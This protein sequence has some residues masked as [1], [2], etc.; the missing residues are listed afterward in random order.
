[1]NVVVIILLLALWAVVLLPGLVRARRAGSPASSVSRFHRDL[2]RLERTGKAAGE[3]ASVG[4]APSPSAR[5]APSTAGRVSWLRAARRDPDAGERHANPA[6]RVRAMAAFR[7]RRRGAST[8]HHRR[9]LGALTV[10][11]RRRVT[12][13]GLLTALALTLVSGLWLGGPAWG[14]TA[15]VGLALVAYCALLRRVTARERSRRVV[16]SR[17]GE[18]GDARGGAG[19]PSGEHSSSEPVLPGPDP[20]PHLNGTAAR[21][22]HDPRDAKATPRGS[23]SDAESATG[24]L[25]AAAAGGS[26]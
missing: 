14:G 3:A 10:T 9:G 11:E 18:P 25:R 16:R 4:R 19:Y 8:A 1:M 20:S 23:L 24:P 6:G 21:G 12:L 17:M 13:M 7:R 26:R 22:P 2:D 15:A 5:P